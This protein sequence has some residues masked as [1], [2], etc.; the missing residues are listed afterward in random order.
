[1]NTTK[2]DNKCSICGRKRGEDREFGYPIGYYTLTVKVGG[3]PTEYQTCSKCKRC[4]IKEVV[5]EPSEF[6]FKNTG[7][8]KRVVKIPKVPESSTSTEELRAVLQTQ[9][10]RSDSERA[11]L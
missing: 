9:K 11:A 2:E 8:R 3:K 4:F 7:N 5:D 6:G 1:M 10:R